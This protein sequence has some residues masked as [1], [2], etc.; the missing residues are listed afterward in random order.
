M[1]ALPFWQ[2]KKLSQM[3]EAEWE[4]IC[5]GCGKCCLVKLQDE[6]TNEIAFTDIACRLLDTDDCHCR[7]YQQ[8]L[9]LVPDCVKLTKDNLAQIN[10]MPPSC[11]YRLLNEGK[12]LPDWHPLVTGKTDSTRLAGRSVS[13]RVV[14]ENATKDDLTD[15]IVTWPTDES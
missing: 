13:G 6:E 2:T 7:H 14:S 8:R 9:E 3:T 11:S 15:H 10:F 5:D 12:P 4:A 1:A